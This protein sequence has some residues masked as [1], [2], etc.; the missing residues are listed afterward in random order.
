MHSRGHDCSRTHG[1][2]SQRVGGIPVC[3]ALAVDC[4]DSRIVLFSLIGRFSWNI[5][6]GARTSDAHSAALALRRALGGDRVLIG[7]GYSMGG[8]I[9]NNY[10]ASYG[11]ACVLDAAIG[12]SGGLDM[13]FQETFFR[14]QRL[15]QPILAEQLRSDFL[16]GKFGKRVHERLSKDEMLRVLRATHVTVSASG[17]GSSLAFRSYAHPVLERQGN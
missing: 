13:R 11:S 16:L 4:L 7:V 15:W 10:V 6:H 17:K 8:I 2:T 5:F 3:L 1:F 14:A 9:M 12:V